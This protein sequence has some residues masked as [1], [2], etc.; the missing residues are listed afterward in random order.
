MNALFLVFFFAATQALQQ[1]RF[2]PSGS[3]TTITDQGTGGELFILVLEIFH[4]FRSFFFFLLLFIP[5][6]VTGFAFE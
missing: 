5:L 4:R 1:L 3:L 6:S 2:G